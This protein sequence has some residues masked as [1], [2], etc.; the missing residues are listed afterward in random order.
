MRSFAC[1]CPSLRLLFQLIFRLFAASYS[2]VIG[3]RRTS[4]GNPHCQ[5]TTHA[6]RKT[7]LH[8]NPT[9]GNRSLIQQLS[10]LSLSPFG[11]EGQGEWVVVKEQTAAEELKTPAGKYAYEL[12]HDKFV[13]R[14]QR[15]PLPGRR[16]DGH[17]VGT[18]LRELNG[19]E[20][21]SPCPLSRRE[22]GKCNGGRCNASS[23]TARPP[24]AA[25]HNL[26]PDYLKI[27]FSRFEKA[28]R[29]NSSGRLCGSSVC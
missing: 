11:R 12:R 16:S 2:L 19:G 9:P 1:S 15:C 5:R 21:H 14:D 26:S 8:E 23:R 4:V 29:P 17:V 13:S 3:S 25:T 6:N 27:T 28:F 20:T 24:Q 18:L 7:N 10:R 22:R